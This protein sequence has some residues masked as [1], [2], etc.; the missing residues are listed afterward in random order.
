MKTVIAGV[1]R[2]SLVPRTV[3]V[4]SADRCGAASC[5][6]HKQVLSLES[7]CL[8]HS[9]IGKYVKHLEVLSVSVCGS[10]SSR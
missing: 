8:L 1:C 9:H 10:L 6:S 3:R 4:L 5:W 7:V 2:Q